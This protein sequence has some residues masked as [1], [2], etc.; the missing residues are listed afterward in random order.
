MLILNGKLGIRGNQKRKNA[1]LYKKYALFDAT[2]SIGG[3]VIKKPYKKLRNTSP[4]PITAR[5]L[6]KFSGLRNGKLTTC[7]YEKLKRMELVDSPVRERRPD[8]L[9]R[10]YAVVD[11]RLEHPEYTAK[12]KVIPKKDCPVLMPCTF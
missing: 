5:Q 1:V 4:I 3:Y 7:D 6:E 10:L 2:F 8:I 12:I 11:W 9:I